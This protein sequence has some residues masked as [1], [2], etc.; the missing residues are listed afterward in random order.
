ML[1]SWS[2]VAKKAADANARLSTS[3]TSM[4]ARRTKRAP[5]VSEECSKAGPK[6]FDLRCFSAA[7]HTS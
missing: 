5:D 4:K 7:I 1:S 2:S 3:E 6:K